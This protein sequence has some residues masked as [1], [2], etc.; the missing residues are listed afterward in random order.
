MKKKKTKK[1]QNEEECFSMEN[2]KVPNESGLTY[3]IKPLCDQV[4]IHPTEIK[5]YVHTIVA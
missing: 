2:L 5:N 4:G 3:D 1:E